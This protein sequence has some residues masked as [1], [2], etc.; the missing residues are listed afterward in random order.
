MS[1]N[2]CLAQTISELKFIL[3][4]SKIDLVCIPLN[5]K[6]L[7]YCEINN[8]EYLNPKNYLDNNFHKKSIETSNEFTSSVKFLEEI[9][10]NIKIEFI[11]YLRFRLH[12][13]LFVTNILDEINKKEK[14]EQ[15]YLSGWTQRQFKNLEG[16]YLFE[17]QDLI[18][19]KF[20][21]NILSKKEI[22]ENINQFYTYEIKGRTKNK[23]KNILLSNL[24][25]NFKRFIFDKYR[26]I[27][28][29]YFI[30]EN[31]VSLL[32]KFIFF[33]LKVTPLFLSKKNLKKN[34]T[35]IKYEF[36][37][38]PKF[39]FGSTL[40]KMMFNFEAYFHNLREKN[41][42]VESFLV[43]NKFDLILS[44]IVRGVGGSVIEIGEK[45]NIK[46][47]CITHGTIAPNFDEHDKI[48]KKIIAEAVFSGNSKNFAIQSKICDKSLKTHK[49]KGKKFISGNI[50]FVQ[51]NSKSDKEYAV[52]AVT[53]KDFFN[54][55][56]FGVEMFYEFNENLK[57]LN[58]I[59]SKGE[60][61]IIVKVHP[62]QNHCVELLK[63]TYKS[64]I[65]SKKSIDK[66]FKKSYATITFSSSVIEDS[67]YS[68]IPVILMD[69]WKRYIH[70]ESEKNPSV[71]NR[72]IYYINKFTDLEK[73]LLNLK[74]PSEINFSEYI[75]NTHYKENISNSI[76]S[77]IK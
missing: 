63:Q 44:N 42:A 38:D 28:N 16:Y 48:Y 67:L 52:Y 70:C 64:L 9:D 62:S 25:Y 69:Q 23:K 17:I 10:Y 27:F 7:L 75:Y 65:F 41:L 30:T 33:C 51:N 21:L 71:K 5:L 60:I 74:S 50:N 73:C 14:I 24:A 31:K 29:F 13:I 35:A 1:K 76:L 55:Q 56:F 40:E 22:S 6:V 45:L 43:S 57:Q 20:K 34:N 47:A 66:L 37:K 26:K 4:K 49:I 39:F 19:N 54:S 2:I 11:A 53:L 12:S 68:K 77:L 36:K 8:I 61:K 32:Q 72:P 15:I 46:T 58:E 18:K 59:S 3:D